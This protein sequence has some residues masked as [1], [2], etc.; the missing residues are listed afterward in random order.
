LW[1]CGLRRSRKPGLSK[2]GLAARLRDAE[3]D[4]VHLPQ[5]GNLRDNRDAFRRGDDQCVALMCFEHDASECHRSMVA[6]ALAKAGAMLQI[7]HL[8]ATTQGRRQLMSVMAEKVIDKI[9]RFAPNI[10]DIQMRHMTFAPYHME[11]MFAAPSGDFCHGL[12]HPDLMGPNRPGPK[13]FL[14]MPIPT[15]GLYL[16][17][18]G[19]HGGPRITF[20]PG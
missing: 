1:T 8:C 16:G 18:A 17:G 2:N 9:T 13:G 20:I 14:D 10:R 3:I 4:Y 6:E 12:L 7:V 5:L 11:T 19:C 15:A